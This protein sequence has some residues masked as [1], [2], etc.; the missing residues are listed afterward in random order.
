MIVEADDPETRGRA[1]AQR[2]VI[3]F[4]DPRLCVKDEIQREE[5]EPITAPYYV[6]TLKDLLLVDLAKNHQ[7][8]RHEAWSLPHLACPVILHLEPYLQLPRTESLSLL[9]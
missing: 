2:L 3:S 6:L 1:R 9:I 8:Q 4:S 5:L 7:D